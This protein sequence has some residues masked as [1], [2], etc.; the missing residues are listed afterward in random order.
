MMYYYYV[1]GILWRIEPQGETIPTLLHMIYY[2]HISM[3]PL[4]L[5]RMNV[6]IMYVLSFVVCTYYL[7][8]F[9]MYYS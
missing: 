1:P 9:L 8:S 3:L 2:Y 6:R 5:R 7:L 4:L